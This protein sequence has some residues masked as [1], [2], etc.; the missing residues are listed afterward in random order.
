MSS[1]TNTNFIPAF[2]YPAQ[3]NNYP[4]PPAYNGVSY[5]QVPVQTNPYAYQPPIQPVYTPQVNP[6]VTSAN[7]PSYPT[8]LYPQMAPAYPVYVNQVVTSPQ[9]GKDLISTEF[10][11]FRFDYSYIVLGR[12]MSPPVQRL[13]SPSA[14]RPSSPSLRRDAPE[15]STSPKPMPTIDQILAMNHTK[16]CK[17]CSKYYKEDQVTGFCK[18]HPGTYR[19]AYES[20]IAPIRYSTWSCCTGMERETPGCKQGDHVEDRETTAKLHMYDNIASQMPQ[21][22][23]IVEENNNSDL[24]DFK[25]EDQVTE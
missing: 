11:R 3:Q 22:A 24:I 5:V 10:S 21:A 20:S 16:R 7:P 12:P 13:T 14:Q 23:S 18:Y 1:N 19:I 6:Y 4:Q 25:S 2:Q 17:R 15:L 8:N 9:R